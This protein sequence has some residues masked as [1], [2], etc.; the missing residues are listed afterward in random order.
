MNDIQTA[1][2][3]GWFSVALGVAEL[4]AGRALAR[5]L[6]LERQIALFRF[7]GAREMAVGAVILAHPDAA[8]GPWARVAGDALD[9]AVLGT[10]LL[11]GNSRRGTAA[12]AAAA[13]AGITVADILCAQA[14][15][16]RK[17]RALA[18]ARRTRVRKAAA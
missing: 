9:L 6:G 12:V 13:V 15:T 2:A 18:T 5:A 3:L 7:F 8:S 14:L 4:V 11:S 17:A 1:R 16:A 10:A